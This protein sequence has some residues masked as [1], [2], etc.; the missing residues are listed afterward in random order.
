M[1]RNSDVRCNNPIHARRTFPDMR[2]HGAKV[3]ACISAPHNRFQCQHAH[4]H[5]HRTPHAEVNTDGPHNNDKQVLF[6]KPRNAHAPQ[7]CAERDPHPYPHPPPYHQFVWRVRPARVC[8][9][10]RLEQLADR[11]VPI[12]AREGE[13]GRALLRLR[14]LARAD[15]GR[16]RFTW[17]PTLDGGRSF[18]RW[19]AGRRPNRPS[20]RGRRRC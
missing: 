6:A 19:I 13:R 11:R 17:R 10:S 16:S 8:P 9:G 2:A 5:A 20:R 12:L 14:V 4:A 1:N 15:R 7:L 18:A 3:C